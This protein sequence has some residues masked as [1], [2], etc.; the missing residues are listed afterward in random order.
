MSPGR[1]RALG[2]A[3]ALALLSVLVW[4]F[5]FL[6]DDAYISF[7]YARNLVQGLG[8]RYNP[9]E[10]P[11]VE[12]YSNLLWILVLAPFQA[13]GGDLASV[14]RIL[15]VASAIG[16]LGLVVRFTVLRFQA[17]G[18]E[19]LLPALFFASLPPIGVW[20]TSGLETLPFALALFGVFHAL[21]ARPACSNGAPRGVLAGL[22][23]ACAV[24]LRADGYVLVGTVLAGALL[25]SMLSLGE[26]RRALLRALAAAGL[27]VATAVVLQHAWRWS[28]HEHLLPNTA[29]AKVG[30][31]GA[32]LR[33]GASYVAGFLLSVPS[34]LL[35]LAT[36]L[37]RA[38]RLPRALFAAAFLPLA[39]IF[40]YAIAVGGDFM[41]MGRFLVPALPLLAVLLA[42]A[43]AAGGGRLGTWI[44]RGSAALAIVLSLLSAGDLN[45]VRASLRAELDPR[46]AASEF[47]SEVEQWRSMK[48]RAELLELKGR[49]LALHTHPGEELIADA[50][51]AVG[52]FSGLHIHD[53]NGLVDPDV[54]SRPWKIGTPG[55]DRGVTA[56]RFFPE[57]PTY[58][59]ALIVPTRVPTP[60]IAAERRTA[61]GL[62]P[63]RVE[64]HPLPAELGFPPGLDLVLQRLCW[65][66]RRPLA[67]DTDRA[68][69]TAFE[70]GNA[71]HAPGTYGAVPRETASE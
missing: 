30:F 18:R 48:Q 45:V 53:L 62:V 4:R 46:W 11:P 70:P 1:S 38:P 28:Y 61:D 36:V 43:L 21:F 58:L 63:V 65:D 24:L 16:L 6:C 32:L 19:V 31:S 15:S 69:V 56:D 20:A 71:A 29:Q 35:V 50:I 42:A 13:A 33:R 14:S 23:G 57:E 37:G 39:L 26:E 59:A 54:A 22:A 3:L 68:P 34:V 17:S 8:L 55:H 25:A 7:R 41:C 66:E 64:R 2:F 40:G 67:R 44:V 52:W 49:A 27:L 12:G 9:T 5:A 47:M 60:P 10:D 51:G